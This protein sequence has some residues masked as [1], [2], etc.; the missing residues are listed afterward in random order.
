MGFFLINKK[1]ISLAKFHSI[2]LQ[3][4]WPGLLFLNLFFIL[5]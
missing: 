2:F 4:G 1:L 5:Y 3:I